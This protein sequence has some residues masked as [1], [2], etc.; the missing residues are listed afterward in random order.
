[1]PIA[2]V[3]HDRQFSFG[4]LPLLSALFWDDVFITPLFFQRKGG[5]EQH[6]CRGCIISNFKHLNLAERGAF[7]IFRRLRQLQAQVQKRDI[8]DL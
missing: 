3:S 7:A 8:A 1:L 4:G 6:C 5:T 2:T